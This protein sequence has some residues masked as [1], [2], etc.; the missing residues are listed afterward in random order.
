MI[1]PGVYITDTRKVGEGYRERLAG[2]RA[3]AQ[4]LID[5]EGDY[6]KLRGPA[7]D[8]YYELRA[9]LQTLL[10]GPLPEGG[11]SPDSDVFANA[12]R[13]FRDTLGHHEARRINLSDNDLRRMKVTL[14]MIDQGRASIGPAHQPGH[15]LKTAIHADPETDL[16]HWD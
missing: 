7:Q 11:A 2:G 13:S 6:R 5:G 14:D 12:A 10:D 4:L 3:P 15:L 8:T 16:I 9:R 1:S